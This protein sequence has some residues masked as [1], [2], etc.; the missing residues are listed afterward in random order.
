MKPANNAPMYAAL[1]P[2]LAE[3]C[4]SFGYALAVHG[5]MSR[6]FDIVALPWAETM[7]G[8][9]EDVVTA[10]CKRFAVTKVSGDPVIMNHGRI[11][12]NLALMG[13]FFFDLSF[14]ATDSPAVKLRAGLNQAIELLTTALHEPEQ[15]T[16]EEIHELRT[17]E[18]DSIGDGTS[19]CVR[20]FTLIVDEDTEEVSYAAL[21]KRADALDLNDEDL[22][23]IVRL[24]V[25]EEL[26]IHENPIVTIIRIV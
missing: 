6:D 17:L 8:G 15:I 21:R 19:I 18:R 13:E 12:Y 16:E 4:R 24:S 10:I 1:Y 23:N 9:P 20:R 7:S 25:Q 2:E 5:T 22:E 11:C 14:I 26:P 3:I